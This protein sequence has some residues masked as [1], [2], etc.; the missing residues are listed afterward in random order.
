MSATIGTI[1]P[2]QESED[3]ETYVDRVELF[4]DANS[5]AD[6]KK[7]STFLSIVGPQVYGLVQNIVSPKKPK[8]C[9]YKDIIKGLQ[10]HYKPK[11]IVVFER[12]K[13]YN[14]S[15]GADES[16][17][18]FVAGLKACAHTCQFG[19]ALKEML[20]DRLIC[21]I[22][23]EA[24]QRA[25]LTEADLTFEKGVEIATAREAAARDVQAMCQPSP[26]VH[27]V[28]V[29]NLMNLNIRKILNL[30]H[31]NLI[32]LN[33]ENH[34]Q[35]VVGITGEMTAHSKMLLA[36]IVIRRAISKNSVMQLKIR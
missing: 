11:V 18:D 20:R 25:L 26:N 36:L 15:Q 33:L 4:F 2:Y 8:D 28:G 1:G 31:L 10:N 17:A 32:Y 6:D 9:T 19:N 24:T 21:G 16:I 27:N 22:R 14:R 7:V 5:I 12:F 35:V 3:F 13:F 30:M 34:V 23:N 29:G